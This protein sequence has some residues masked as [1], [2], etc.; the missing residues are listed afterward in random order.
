MRMHFFKR[1]HHVVTKQ[2]TLISCFTI[3]LVSLCE[4]LLY[5]SGI[6]LKIFFICKTVVYLIE[7]FVVASV[8]AIYFFAVKLV[9]DYHKDYRNKSLS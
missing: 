9:K 8:T 1:Y 3:T 7:F 2:G 5:T 4:G 6:E